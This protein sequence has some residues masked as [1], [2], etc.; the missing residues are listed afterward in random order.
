MR[1]RKRGAPRPYLL[2]LLE[3]SVESEEG[4]TREKIIKR[5]R[6]EREEP[7]DQAP[8]A[9]TEEGAN[10]DENG[11]FETYSEKLVLTPTID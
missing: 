4:K 10:S 11:G 2:L 8:T 6:A 1:Q 3:P 5:K 7:K 9:T